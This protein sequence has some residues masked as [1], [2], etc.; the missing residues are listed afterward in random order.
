MGQAN[1]KRRAFGVLAAF[2]L[3]GTHSALA[4]DMPVKA[5]V[6]DPAEPIDYGNLYYGVDAN[7]IGALVGYSGMIYA[8]GSMDNSGLRIA[9]FGL[10]GK[11]R[12]TG[13]DPSNLGTTFNA[14]FASIDMLA[15]YSTVFEKGSATLA[16]GLNYQDH[17]VTPF[18]PD[19]PVQGQK[20]GFKTQADFDINPTPLTMVSGIASYSTAFRTYYSILKTGYDF[21][22]KE[23]FIGPE[24]VA[25]GNERTDQQ[26]VG[27]RFSDIH[28]A[29]RVS[30]SVS[31]G[32][33]H[34]RNE[35]NGAYTTATID[36]TF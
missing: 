31:A 23:F 16:I 34:E 27:L 6:A 12:Y 7:T 19:N 11:Y 28:L 5:P 1:M 32:W 14:R 24:F 30:L 35:P 26:R 33:L 3:L 36:F 4:A 2:C 18:D 21:F 15:G 17:I 29:N 22:G 20:L 9:L 25:L 8:P 13:D 10:Y